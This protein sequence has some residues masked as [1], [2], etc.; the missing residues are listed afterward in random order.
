VL[1]PADR[2]TLHELNGVRYML[3]RAE[4]QLL[5]KADNAGAADKNCQEAVE[6]LIACTGQLNRLIGVLHG[7]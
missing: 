2:L 3:E 1:T 5:H 7:V 4:G 6:L